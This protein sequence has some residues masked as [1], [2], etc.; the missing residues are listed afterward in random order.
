MN[1]Y[2]FVGNLSTG[3]V[4]FLGMATFDLGG[5]E[6]GTSTDPVPPADPRIPMPPGFFT[7][8]ETDTPTD[9][10]G[11]VGP[12]E[13][14]DPEPPVKPIP[15]RRGKPDFE[16]VYICSRRSGHDGSGGPFGNGSSDCISGS[17]VYDCRPTII[18][19]GLPE[20]SIRIDHTTR[21][22]LRSLNKWRL[23]V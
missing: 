18:D 13:P 14:I 15:P 17:C 16:G 5:G 20:T 10:V 9:P 8:E 7:P 1:L 4:D 2:G 21:Q 23:G 12:V 6:T 11:P 3:R 22:N 19:K